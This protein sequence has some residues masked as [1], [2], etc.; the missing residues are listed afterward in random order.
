VTEVSRDDGEGFA[1]FYEDWSH[2]HRTKT[3]EKLKEVMIFLQH[4]IKKNVVP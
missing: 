3:E 2:N 4:N 1:N